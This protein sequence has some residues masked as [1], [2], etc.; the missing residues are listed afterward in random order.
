MFVSFISESNFSYKTKTMKQ[1]VLFAVKNA[2][3]FKFNK[4]KNYTEFFETNKQKR[5]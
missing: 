5:M 4:K 2:N 3:N 1:S